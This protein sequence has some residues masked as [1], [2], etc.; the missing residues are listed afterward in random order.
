MS[1]RHSGQADNGIIARDLL[2]RGNAVG[3]AMEELLFDVRDP[4]PTTAGI[5]VQCKNA[6]IRTD[7][8]VGGKTRT[9]EADPEAA[10]HLLRDL[11]LAQRGF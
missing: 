7:L 8:V 11:D 2:L 6:K 4:E 5:D 9:V 10:T 3:V 1:A